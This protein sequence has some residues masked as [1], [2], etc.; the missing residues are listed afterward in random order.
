MF[1]KAQDLALNL[2]GTNLENVLKE[3]EAVYGD[4]MELLTKYD[5]FD[6]FNRGTDQT[7]K[8]YI[9]MSEY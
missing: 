3:M 1:G 9:H 6:A 5:E 4:S 8:E 2:T 7:L